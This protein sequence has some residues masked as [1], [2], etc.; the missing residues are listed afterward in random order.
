MTAMSDII[1]LY[2][3]IPRRIKQTD[4]FE[5][6][7]PKQVANY[8]I[9]GLVCYWNAHYVCFFKS[10]DKDEHWVFYDDNMVSRIDSWKD[11]ISKS[12]KGHFYPVLLFYKK[13][14]KSKPDEIDL[15]NE[16]INKMMAYCLNYDKE[17]TAMYKTEH[18]LSARLRPSTEDKRLSDRK[19]L[20]PPTKSLDE[21]Q[22]EILTE[23]N[24][25]FENYDFNA[26]NK[27]NNT[28][29]TNS[30]RFIAHSHRQSA[31]IN[32]KEVYEQKE[33]KS[34]DNKKESKKKSDPND[35]Q[36]L[37]DE[38]LCE[39]KSCKNINKNTSYTCL[40]CKT[41]NNAMFDQI[42]QK[43]VFNKPEED[44]KKL[45][46]TKLGTELNAKKS[47]QE[48]RELKANICQYCHKENYYT[49]KLC[50]SCYA[51]IN[52]DK[53]HNTVAKAL[54]HY[55]KKPIYWTCAYCKVQNKEDKAYCEYCKKNKTTTLDHKEES[56]VIEQK[57][58]VT[59]NR[60]QKINCK[61][62]NDEYASVNSP[63]CEGCNKK[64]GCQ[65]YRPLAKNPLTQEL[66]NKIYARKDVN[67]TLTSVSS[68]MQRSGIMK[69]EYDQ[70]EG[71]NVQINRRRNHYS[72]S[73]IHSGSYSPQGF[74]TSN[75]NA[76]F[77]YPNVRGK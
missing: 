75:K 21:R 4:V 16:E 1:K 17:V 29:N 47:I 57:F 45:F 64:R 39:V 18:P 22:A 7:D 46:K 40:K 63:Y 74:K 62:C 32:N 26:K 55:E 77:N 51:F 2:L 49:E 38:W 54:D 36:L 35:P 50:E 3:M 28:A 19:N 14:K 24:R 58:K 33:K 53:P 25:N 73:V 68:D 9:Y 61:I 67:T 70:Y 60:T 11:L 59:F 13:L 65:T 69:S 10:E 76:V 8:E 52:R 66:K 12:L 5:L 6:T 44:M 72:P 31:E 20:P 43:K 48:I 71:G 34:N 56:K 23:L 37:E 27:A 42:V 30:G 41:I 15:T